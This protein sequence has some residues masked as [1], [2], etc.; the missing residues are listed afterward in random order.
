M[1][2]WLKMGWRN[3]WRNRGR[4]LLQVM[5]IA[6]GLL[7]A[8]FFRNL[9]AGSYEKM[10]YD[11]TRSGSGHVGFYHNRYLKERKTSFCFPSDEILSGLRKE[12][13]IKHIFPRLIIPGLVQSSR[14]SKGVLVLGM[15]IEAEKEANPLLDEKKLLSGTL[16]IGENR[17]KILI[18]LKMSQRLQ[19]KMGNKIVVSFQNA[20]GEIANE[21][22]RVGGI[23]QTGISQ[24]DSDMAFVDRETLSKMFGKTGVL[25]EIAVVL[26]NRH[27]VPEFLGRIKSHITMPGSVQAF[28]W[29]EAMPELYSAIRLDRVQFYISMAILYFLISIGAV[30]TLLMSVTERTREFGLM[31]ALGLNSTAIRKI[32]LAEALVLGVFGSMLGLALG[33]MASSYTGKYGLDLS[34]LVGKTEMAGILVDPI[35]FSVWDIPAMVVAVIAMIVLVI[36]TSL[37]PARRALKI[38][39][40]EAMRKY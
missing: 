5:A 25:H 10:I 4:T 6:G 30:N 29:M 2:I 32:I 1:L 36:V 24:I 8:I 23:F 31:R 18:G 37:Y 21:L 20:D 16:P 9:A 40:S 28:P 27:A 15:D 34:S 26:E 17:T 39:P 13:G 22:F 14:E 12:K 33:I 19:V 3:L 7:I 38:R 35:I 11:G